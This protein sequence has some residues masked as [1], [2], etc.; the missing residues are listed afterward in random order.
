MNEETTDIRRRLETAV[1]QKLVCLHQSGVRQL[2]KA[3][4]GTTRAAWL[5]QP[6]STA[7]AASA[8]GGEP[9]AAPT[10]TPSAAPPA[11]PL[12]VLRQ[13]VT[14][15]T[16]CPELVENRT[17]TVFG[18]GDPHARLCFLGEAP[19]ADEDR[20]GEPFVGKAG[21]LLER[22]IAAC[23]LRREQV[24]ILNVLKCRPP[25]N[26]T[27]GPDEVANC[28]FFFEKQL[29]IIAPEFICCLG[30]VAAQALLQT[31][32]SVGKLRGRFHD[33][34]NSKVVVTYHPAYLLRSPD[35]KRK[36]WEDMK[37]LMRAM[38]IE[39]PNP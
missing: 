16:L 32:D 5:S 12:E 7:Q 13:E 36:T 8:V 39:I 4:P 34:R 23:T 28:R 38:G 3:T 22:I 20:Q 19:G 24:F 9:A 31:T 27:P 37:M 10:A 2:R 11:A 1:Q 26:R 6:G 35:Q 21:Q 33:Y 18:A 25:G 14:A 17:Q 29:E 30:A 15:C